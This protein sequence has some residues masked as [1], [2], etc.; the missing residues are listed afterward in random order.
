MM[1]FKR[2]TPSMNQSKILQKSYYASQTLLPI[3]N[4]KYWFSEAT[5][6]FEDVEWLPVHNLPLAMNSYHS[7]GHDH[8]VIWR[9]NLHSVFE[10]Q[11]WHLLQILIGLIDRAAVVEWLTHVEFILDWVRRQLHGKFVPVLLFNGPY[12]ISIIVIF[13]FL[14]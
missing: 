12:Q 5:C 2:I 13:Y 11:F 14:L 8:F 1:E 4:P 7:W 3:N 9:A 6:G 10:L